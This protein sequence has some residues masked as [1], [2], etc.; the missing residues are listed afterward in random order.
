VLPDPGR[1]GSSC[2]IGADG[3]LLA[4]GGATIVNDKTLFLSDVAA[5]Q[6]EPIDLS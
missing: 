2:A 1:G 4:I 5:L 3:A 6:L